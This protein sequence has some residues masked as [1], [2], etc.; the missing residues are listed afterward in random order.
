MRNKFFIM[1]AII[2][3]CLFVSLTLIVG[4][5]GPKNI[6]FNPDTPGAPQNRTALVIGN[7]AY[8]SARLENTVKDAREM[9]GVLE[10]LG[11]DVIRGEDLALHEM[12][13]AIASFGRVLA[14]RRGVGLF[15]YAGHAGEASGQN[16][17]FPTD[18][19]MSS[20]LNN[21]VEMDLVINAMKT[22][23][24]AK[25]IIIMDACRER[26]RSLRNRN[27]IRGLAAM[28]ASMY[29]QGSSFFIAYSTSPGEFASDN[30]GYTSELVRFMQKEDLKIED[31]FKEVSR[32]VKN[33]T[34]ERQIPWI[35]SNLTDDF[36]FKTADTAPVPTWKDPGTGIEFIGVKGGWYSMGCEKY[37]AGNCEKDEMPSHFVRV[38]D[39]YLSKY[40]ITSGQWNL[41]LAEHIGYHGNGR[42]GPNCI[43]A[44][45]FQKDVLR[46]NVPIVC[47]SWYEANDF[48]QWLTAKTGKKFSL[49]TE[50]QWEYACRSGG[51]T[52]KFAGGYNDA[53]EIAWYKRNSKRSPC[54]VGLNRPN[55]LGLYDMTGNVWEWCQD[56]YDK[57]AYEKNH[58]P[59]GDPKNQP[60]VL[61]GGSWITKETDLRCPNRWRHHPSDRLCYAGFRLVMLPSAD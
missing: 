3:I 25:N 45:Q 53:R 30:S 59:K 7:A 60:R 1:K 55:G 54:H 20:P 40:E 57:H 61:R 19:N 13:K 47:V 29:E 33:K 50:M 49:P 16:Y 10:N 56:T 6:V 34:K 9:A 41:F 27:F 44:G 31:V 12:K 24:T 26:F 14:S 36:Y 28:S 2:F 22:A 39:F 5:P 52:E 35:N 58:P 48:A 32:I 51:K 21:A 23:G 11:Y 17:L 37:W 46:D 4:C 43:G 15:Y 38:D 42:N 18:T 8:P